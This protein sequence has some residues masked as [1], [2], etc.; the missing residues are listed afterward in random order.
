MT[1]HIGRRLARHSLV[2]FNKEL[3]CTVVD[4]EERREL[5]GSIINSTCWL[6]ELTTVDCLVANSYKGEPK[7]LC[8]GILLLGNSS[9][10]WPQQLSLGQAKA[11][12]G[13]S[14]LRMHLHLLSACVPD[15]QYLTR[16]AR[17]ETISSGKIRLRESIPSPSIAS[18]RS[19]NNVSTR[20]NAGPYGPQIERWLLKQAAVRTPDSKQWQ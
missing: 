14:K 3:L 10:L 20:Q 7:A 18:N 11:A 16:R 4:A 9:F 19:R 6:A 12:K 17:V 15:L 1:T 8:L 2:H 5:L 13:V